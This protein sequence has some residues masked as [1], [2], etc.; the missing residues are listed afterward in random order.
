MYFTIP[1]DPK[2]VTYNYGF[3]IGKESVTEEWLNSKAKTAR[4]YKTVFYR[5]AKD[6]E[7]DLVGIPKEERKTIERSL[8]ERVL[9]V[10]SGAALNVSVCK[11]IKNWFLCNE[12][13]D[14]GNSIT[15]LVM[16]HTLPTDF[17]DSKEIQNDVVD[18][19]NSFDESIVG[20]SVKETAPDKYDVLAHHRMM[21]SDEIAKI[22]LEE[23]SS[24]TLKMFSLYPEL[25]EVLTSGGV[26]FI[27]ELNARLHPL[28]VRNFV[29]CFLNPEI[30]KKHVQLIFTTHDTWQ[31]SSDL[32]RRDE[33]WFAD[34][35][36]NGIS[37]LFSLA[38]FVDADGAKIRKDENYAKDYMSGKYSAIPHLRKMM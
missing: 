26:Y 2:E 29:L 20:F 6:N 11:K 17:A 36:E 10:S 3:S 23:E 5:S 32:F 33:I 8:R 24:G 28:L 15:N 30:N 9:L 35:D 4:S 7:L 38:D 27:D 31:L 22:P 14:F 25:K 34:K 1:E 18:F 12:F 16:S 19:F 21:G 13:A 37:T